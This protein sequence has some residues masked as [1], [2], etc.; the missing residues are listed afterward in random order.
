MT[1]HV[2]MLLS[3]GPVQ[4]LIAS[5]RRCR[6]L[7]FGSWLL[8]DAA[9][10][11]AEHV[12]SEASKHGA[13]SDGCDALVFPGATTREGLARERRVAN[14]ILARLPV[15]VDQ[16][17]HIARGA[18][19]A[20]RDRLTQLAEAAF[21]RPHQHLAK[22]LHRDAAMAQV[23]D[24]LD[25]QWVIVAEGDAG[26]DT[27]RRN[28]DRLL[29]ARK[30][31]RVWD[32]PSWSA[33]VPKSSVDGLRESVL[34]EA[35][36]DAI[37]K[38]DIAAKDAYDAFR[39]HPS[40]R[41]CGVAL[42]K[43]L[44]RD[45]RADD[46]PGNDR[47]FS[48]SHL[49][50]LPTLVGAA[51]ADGAAEAFDRFRDALASVYP[52]LAD[53]AFDVVPR[54]LPPFGRVDGQLLFESRLAELAEELEGEQSDEAPKLREARK[55]IT[56]FRKALNLEPLAYYAVLLA[57]GDRMGRAIDSLAD[58]EKHR[59]L[60]RALADFATEARDIVES[61]A[62][63]GSL[64]YSGG[65]D[66]LALLPLHGVLDCADRLREAFATHLAP[67][68]L[69]PET[70]T[71]SVGVAIGHHLTP[72][73]ATLA[74][75]RAAERLAKQERNSFAL[76]VDKRSGS[77]IALSRR[78][79]EPLPLTERLRR[80]AKAHRDRRSPERK[81]HV[82]TTERRFAEAHRRGELSDKAAFEL[83]AL[84]EL[85]QPRS[86]HPGLAEIDGLDAVVAAEAERVLR[87]KALDEAFIAELRELGLTREPDVLGRELVVPRLFADAFDRAHP[88]P[89][90]DAEEN[91]A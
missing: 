48:T 20:A 84:E 28:A 82:S 16:A 81:R 21:A 18:A 44:G 45:D 15:D 63:H 91:A 70:P 41:L 85:A 1:D 66:V 24:L 3:I 90:P 43:R 34:D 10:T 83:M 69:G 78:W 17:A 6:D 5:A 60:S 76:V 8:A 87:G 29:A 77:D 49:A 39:I 75:A 36:Y 31:T 19:D 14:R 55:A 23:A 4:D 67:L 2:V 47:F 79:D 58:F 7:W 32:P 65:D 62:H 9:R 27:A 26:Y 71:L 25:I 68:E 80:F 38:G 56:G 88:T 54:A 64:V 35:L 72:L 12:A 73:D 33:P 50:A 22:H 13:G 11:A 51:K 46:P 74:Q 42:L 53:H 59:R 61:D 30:Q 52:D 57:D 40:E 37:A 89:A 86:R